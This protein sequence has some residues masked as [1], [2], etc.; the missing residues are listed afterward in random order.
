LGVLYTVYEVFYEGEEMPEAWWRARKVVGTLDYSTGGTSRY[1]HQVADV[2]DADYKPLL[3]RMER[4]VVTPYK[5][6]KLV[7]S[8]EQK[9]VHQKGMYWNKRSYVQ[10]WLCIPCK[11][12]PAGK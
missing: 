5:N 7:I 9:A 11:E 3:G 4:A 2:L 10:E 12:L 8:G 6:G 1:P